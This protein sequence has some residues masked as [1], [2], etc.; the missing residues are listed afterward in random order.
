MRAS[1]VPA[2]RIVLVGFL[3]AAGFA[4][5]G[6]S[7][8]EKLEAAA[9]AAGCLLN[10]D[11]N[12]P[13]VCAFRRCHVE[14]EDSRDCDDGQRC[15]ASDRPFRVCQ[16]DDE[17]ACTR[18]SDCPFGM[19]CGIDGE[20][21]DQCATDRDC[22]PGQLCTAGSCADPEELVDGE[23]PEAP[24]MGADAGGAT[25]RPCLYSSECP[26]PLICR[27]SFCVAECIEDR[28]CPAGQS[29]TSGSC[30][31]D[32]VVTADG[33]PP[34]CVFSSDCANPSETCVAGTCRCQCQ[35]SRD[36]PTGMTCDGCGC[37]LADASAGCTFNSDCGAGQI[38]DQGTCRCECRE[39]RDCPTAMSCDG[40]GCVGLTGPKPDGAPDS[41]GAGCTLSS[42]CDFPLV[43]TPTGVCAFECATN[44][45]CPAGGTCCFQNQCVTGPVCQ[46]SSDAGGTD[47]GGSDA[48]TPCVSN[49][50]CQDSSWCNGVERC[51]AGCCRPAADTP[52]NSHS[53]CIQ[54]MCEESTQT[55]SQITLAGDDVDG[56][57]HLDFACGGD[58]CD[59]TE[60]NTFVGAPEICDGLDNDCN[61]LV[62]DRSRRPFGPE[63][64]SANAGTSLT[65]VGAPV[66]GGFVKFA[67]IF[68]ATGFFLTQLDQNG[69]SV[70]SINFGG[71]E[72]GQ[73][74]KVFDASSG[75]GTALAL[76][77][78]GVS[79]KRMRA[80]LVQPDLTVISNIQLTAPVPASTLGEMDSTWTGSDYF[81]AWVG[82][83]ITPDLAQ[84]A[85]LTPTGSLGPGAVVPTS[86]M[87]GVVDDRIDVASSGATAAVLYEVSGQGLLLSIYNSSNQLRV[88]Q[89][90]LPA[91][92]ASGEQ[93]ALAGT[94]NGYV[95]A[96]KDATGS[97]T[98]FIDVDGNIGATFAIPGSPPQ[99]GDGATDGSGAMF[100]FD[101][102]GV[103]RF[104]YTRGDAPVELSQVVATQANVIRATNIAGS[105]GEFAVFYSEDATD[106][107]RFKRV[108]CEPP[109]GSMAGDAGTD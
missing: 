57:G 34:Q 35:D 103:A 99:V 71:Q 49:F 106:A 101:Y 36:C 37:Q 16:L 59:D 73:D 67:G 20:C 89:I 7:S 84:V 39:D 45:D 109:G 15:V 40:C 2:I 76:Y 44:I 62:D 65:A 8:A 11:C 13:L 31:L 46:T 96:W 69:G 100:V 105:N 29:C 61:L 30:T 82:D 12:P 91:A 53:A 4:A 25:A 70:G 43:C 75:A 18:N 14:C 19:I 68:G 33:G 26:T 81:I 86:A 22:I 38:C 92:P 52:C 98:T 85:R 102:N 48:C 79:T 74:A 64:I 87:D 6:G 17:R 5:C 23:L 9:L 78:S 66:P 107:L 51:F 56:D 88:G 28:D 83:G 72:L 50:D 60:P 55:C 54:D 108:G 24:G 21:R 42:D 97:F 10:T 41:F 90:V 104:G 32:P 94:V 95:A 27:Q 47:A 58:D 63:L 80:I 3:T 93:L 77:W 1:L